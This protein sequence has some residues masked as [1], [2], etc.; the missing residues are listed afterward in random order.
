MFVNS[1]YKELDIPHVSMDDQKAGYLAAKHLTECG[2]SRI[3][4]IFKADDG[5]G[6]LRYAGYTDALMEQDI[7]I[8]GDQ[9]IWIDSEELRVHGGGER[10]VF[11]TTGKGVRP[12]SV[13]TMRQHI[14]WSA[15]SRRPDCACRRICPSWG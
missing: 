8:R 7:R 4:G 3:G 11:K 1:Y 2:H 13:T 14:S 6:H 15:F 5:Q 9:V 10:Q 12:V